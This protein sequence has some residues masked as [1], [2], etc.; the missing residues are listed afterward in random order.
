MRNSSIE[1]FDSERAHI[2]IGLL[3]KSDIASLVSLIMIK[4]LVILECSVLIG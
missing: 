4:Q 1:R 3:Q 2:K